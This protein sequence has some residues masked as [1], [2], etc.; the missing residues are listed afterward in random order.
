MI[1]IRCGDS[2]K[3]ALQQFCEANG[4]E[5][6]AWMRTTMLEIAAKN[7]SALAA[8]ALLGNQ[9]ETAAANA[10]KRAKAGAKAGAK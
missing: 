9:L 5:L 6:S 8:D 4:L 2:E 7:G 3:R 1:T 10:R